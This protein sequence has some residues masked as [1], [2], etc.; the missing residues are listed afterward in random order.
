[1]ERGAL[2]FVMV[3][4]S[5]VVSVSSCAEILMVRLEWA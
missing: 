4:G 5:M 1:M 2:G 3:M